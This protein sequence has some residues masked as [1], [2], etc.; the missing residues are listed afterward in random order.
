MFECIT[1]APTPEEAAEKPNERANQMASFGCAGIFFGVVP[2]FI[3]W[4]V[5]HGIAINQGY[6]GKLVPAASA[7]AIAVCLCAWTFR[8]LSRELNRSKARGTQAA[9]DDSLIEEWRIEA[10]RVVQLIPH[11]EDEPVLCFEVE[12]NRIVMLKGQWLWEESTYGAPRIK[13]DPDENFLNGLDK[14]YSFPSRKFTVIRWPKS[15][16]VA[17]IRVS[18]DYM[19]PEE[20]KV[21]IKRDHYFHASEQFSGQLDDLQSALDLAAAKVAPRMR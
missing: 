7:A 5:F 1:R 11:G 12:P 6:Q 9:A 19:A 21:E 13:D 4:R 17:G 18:G 8:K 15:G 16:K 20:S 2:G 10:S 14:P 3:L